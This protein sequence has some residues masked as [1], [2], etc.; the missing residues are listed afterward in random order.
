MTFLF[1]DIESST[2]RWQEDRGAMA[3]ALA[4]H[5]AV[6]ARI[7]ES[8]DGRVFKHTGDGVCAVFESA[9]RAA[10]AAREAQASLALPVRMGLHTGEAE[11][12]DGDFFG[13]TLNRCARIMDAGHGGQVLASAATRALLDDVEVVDLGDHHVK[14]IDTP[15]R[16]YQLG[17]GTFPPLRSLGSRASLPTVLTTLV[18]R[19]ELLAT[20]VDELDRSRL[21]TLVGVGGVGKTRLAIAV[22]EQVSAD[23]D[24]TVFVD[25]SEVDDEHEVTAALARTFGLTTQT[26]EAITIALSARS[27]LIVLD[28]CEHVLDAVADLVCD[29]LELSPAV[30]VLATSREGLAVPG[31]QLVAVPGLSGSSGDSAAV[32]LFVDRARSVD[33]SFSLSSDGVETVSEICRRLDG[34]PLAIELAAARV[35]VMTVDDLLGHLDARFQM[36]TGGSR[37]RRRRSKQ[38]TLRETIDWS[39]QLL[40]PAEQRAFGRL[41]VFGGSFGL[42]GA[43]AVLGASSDVAVLDMVEALVDKSLLTVVDAAGHRRYRY[44][45][46]LRVYA[47]DRLAEAG[48][49]EDVMVL[50]H[51]HLCATVVAAVEELFRTSA[52]AIRLRIEIPNLQRA[53]DHAVGC[54]DAEAAAALITPFTALM[55][56]IHW[57]IV[58]WAAVALLLPTSRGTSFEPEL[59]ALDA[60]DRWLADEFGDLHRRADEMLRVGEALGA[61]SPGLLHVVSQLYSLIGDDEA[62]TEVNRR[63]QDVAEPGPALMANVVSYWR[64]LVPSDPSAVVEIGE[65]IDD[66]LQEGLAAPSRLTRGAAHNVAALHARAMGDHERMRASAQS[67]AEVAIVGSGAWFAAMQIEAWAD[68]ELGDFD[69]AVRTADRDLEQAYRHGDRSA[70]ILPLTIYAV[71]LHALGEVEAAAIVRGALPRRLTLMMV[72]ELAALD[73]RLAADL[74]ADERRVLAERGRSM[75][76]RQLQ[77]FTHELLGERLGLA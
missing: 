20:V 17:A 48:E 38:R 43:A 75:E 6:L 22:A 57:P 54:G 26:M 69:A 56:T 10:N 1:T 51:E 64:G 60:V 50:L 65:G 74:G 52:D 40:D 58:G 46:T 62:A 14:G 28:N 4:E 37:G 61:V 53:F 19:D 41:S 44:L 18:G 31:E 66:V 35:G 76:P 9:R 71:V 3:S 5:D 11:S 45:E 39:Y 49:T 12:R 77:Q 24:R 63:L 70:M 72:A 47:E 23:H 16:I 42:D 59:L 33:A 67:A 73:R 36:L 68:Y 21:V 34:L 30:R 25:L 32:A 27:A 29:V 8:N 55:T 15:E 13:P 7:V 2:Q